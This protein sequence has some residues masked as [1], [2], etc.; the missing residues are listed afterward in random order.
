MMVLTELRVTHGLPIATILEDHN[1]GSYHARLG[2]STMPACDDHH[3][4]MHFVR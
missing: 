3:S 2:P 1:V 4:V